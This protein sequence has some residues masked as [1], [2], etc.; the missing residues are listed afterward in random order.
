VTELCVNTRLTH[1]YIPFSI[2]LV[3]VI[4]I[5]YINLDPLTLQLGHQFI[6]VRQDPFVRMVLLG[7]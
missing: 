2:L 3:V 5:P 7:M 6:Y 4:I 1:F